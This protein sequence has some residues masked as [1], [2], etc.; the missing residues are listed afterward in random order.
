MS[1]APKYSTKWKK[2][3]SNPSTVKLPSLFSN[4]TVQLQVGC[5]ESFIHYSY[6]KICVFWT[7]LVVG[8]ELGKVV[9]CCVVRL[10]SSCGQ[11]TSFLKRVEIQSC[12]SKVYQ[13]YKVEWNNFL[14][15]LVWMM[16]GVPLSLAIFVLFCFLCL[17]NLSFR[18]T[19]VLI[20]DIVKEWSKVS[21]KAGQVLLLGCRAWL[22]L[23]YKGA[24][25]FSF[26]FFPTLIFPRLHWL[27]PLT[28]PRDPM[29]SLAVPRCSSLHPR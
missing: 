21:K 27:L 2:K 15:L 7:L 8:Q 19:L 11:C 23:L 14:V 29:V 16:S 28:T 6:I 25:P 20:P 1:V 12:F 3:Q 22:A 18:K 26:S 10:L 5:R 17:C 13:C 4:S 24:D 9:R